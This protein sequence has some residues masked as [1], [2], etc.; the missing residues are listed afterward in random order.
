MRHVI[1]TCKN[2]PNL[3]WSCKEIAFIDRIGYTGARNIFF[4]GVPT[5]KWYSD[6]SGIECSR[7]KKDSTG[8]IIGLVEECDCSPGFLIKAPEDALAEKYYKKSLKEF[9]KKRKANKKK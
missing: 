6:K 7:V 1:L 9:E 8:E 2:H 4:N 5:G 3:R